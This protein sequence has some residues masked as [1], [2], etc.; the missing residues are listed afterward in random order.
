M[1]FE[2]KRGQFEVFKNLMCK[3][4]LVP[5]TLVY[6]VLRYS[7]T[8]I[9]LCV[10]HLYVCTTRVRVYILLILGTSVIGKFQMS[11]YS[12][13]SENFLRCLLVPNVIL[14]S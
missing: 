13:F 6:T 11:S 10:Q 5:G 7:S 1:D 3:T 12:Y 8:G 9:Y 2:R 14:M 4:I